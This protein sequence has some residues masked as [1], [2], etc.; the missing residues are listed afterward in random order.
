MSGRT[1]ENHDKP[2]AVQPVS[3]ER[4]KPGTSQSEVTARTALLDALEVIIPPVLH[5]PLPSGGGTSTIG[6]YAAA[7]LNHSYD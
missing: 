4:F 6:P 5:I 7:P 2:Q 3:R 1:D